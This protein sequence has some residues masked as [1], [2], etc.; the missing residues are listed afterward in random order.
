M[1]ASC[2]SSS[3]SASRARF[4]V[5]GRHYPAR[6]RSIS[7]LRSAGYRA[8]PFGTAVVLQR[9]VA[10]A[11]GRRSMISGSGYRRR[12]VCG[13]RLVEASSAGRVPRQS[14]TDGGPSIIGP[15]DVRRVES[16]VSRADPY[17]VDRRRRLRAGR[18][19]SFSGSTGSPTGR[20]TRRSRPKAVVS[21]EAETVGA[22]WASVGGD[23]TRW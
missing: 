4:T 13:C 15:S 17:P 8:G 2:S 5:S 20:R 14:P 23:G 3:A 22:F 6:Y 10:T 11:S 9:E 12:P 16:P 18:L 1:S 7:P 19:L 21:G